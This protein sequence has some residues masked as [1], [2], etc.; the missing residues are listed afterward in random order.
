MG[1]LLANKTILVMGVAN[2]RS[3]AWGCAQVM[4]LI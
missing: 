2:R 4:P 1:D 3:I